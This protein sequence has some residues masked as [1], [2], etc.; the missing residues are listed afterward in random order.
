MEK[1]KAWAFTFLGSVSTQIRDPRL[2][3]SCCKIWLQNLT[4][5]CG[6]C[7]SIWQK[8]MKNMTR[9]IWFWDT[10][11]NSGF[12]EFSCLLCE[13]CDF[14]LMKFRLKG[15]VIIWWWWFC[16]NKKGIFRGRRCWERGMVLLQQE[17]DVEGRW[18]WGCFN[19]KGF[20]RGGDER[21]NVERKD[22][23]GL[24]QSHLL[25]WLWL[26]HKY[27]WLLW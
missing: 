11:N 8:W 20:L 12:R 26:R 4:M 22:E 3:V 1:T 17:R 15:S 14:W 25:I 19:K 27:I 5:A 9:Q 16:F 18:W 10:Q 7:S 21:K 6:K 24:Y 13:S 2:W 23:I